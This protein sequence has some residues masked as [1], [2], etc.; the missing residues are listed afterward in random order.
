MLMKELK[1]RRRETSPFTAPPAPPRAAIFVE[2]ELV[3][4]IEFAEWTREGIMRHP[5]YK[6]LRDDKPA[7][8]VVREVP[9]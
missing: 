7:A 4:E 9:E 1:P 2:P 3:A 8:A 5:A 6:G